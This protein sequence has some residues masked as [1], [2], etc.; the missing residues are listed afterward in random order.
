MSLLLGIPC[1][2]LVH[3]PIIFVS[4]IASP[5]YIQERTTDDLKEI[6]HLR[7]VLENRMQQYSD[8]V[9]APRFAGYN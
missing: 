8:D 4:H 2:R 5:Q 6:D 9:L 7:N 1:N 3:T